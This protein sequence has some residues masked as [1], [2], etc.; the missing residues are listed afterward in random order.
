[1]NTSISLD[2]FRR[3]NLQSVLADV[4]G[5]ECWQYHMVI[6]KLG[7]ELEER[8]D[9]EAG[10]AARLLSTVCSFFFR[11][12]KGLN[13]WQPFYI[14]GGERSPMADDLE[15]AELKSLGDFI[16]EIEDPELKARVADVLWECKQGY[17]FGRIAVEAYQRA[18]EI[19]ENGREW[20]HFVEKLQRAASLAAKLERGKQVHL[21]VIARIEEKVAK[22][23]GD[24]GSGML[25]HELL[26]VVMAHGFGN[27]EAYAALCER[28]GS[29]FRSAKQWSFS[30]SYWSLAAAWHRRAKNEDDARRCR[31]QE[32]ETMVA[33]AQDADDRMRIG[34][35]YSAGW[36]MRGIEILRETG[37]DAERIAV[38]HAEM[39]GLQREALNDL[40]TF[41]VD[42]RNIPG[43]AETAKAAA[44]DV[45]KHL[46][47]LRLDEA[48]ARLANITS[49]TDVGE[50]RKTMANA[51]GD[52]LHQ[53]V[54][55]GT[56]D[57]EGKITDQ[58]EGAAVTEDPSE[59]H[60]QKRMFEW[61]KMSLWPLACDWYIEPA[62][63]TIRLEHRLR[64]Q[65]L[66]FLVSPNP[67]VPIGHEEIYLRGVIAGFNDDHLVATHLLVPQ[68]EHSIRMILKRSGFLT[69]TLKS[70][71]QKEMDLGGLL[72][73]EKTIEIFGED[74]IFDLRGILIEKF[75]ENLRNNMAH[76]FLPSSSFN[77]AGSCYL[78]W[79][80]VRLLWL[81]YAG[82]QRP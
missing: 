76:G 47:G 20:I 30:V 36:L 35:S 9:A 48:I 14:G 32:G 8:G 29:D 38:L 42:P 72:T 60:L 16:D 12:S 24:L 45:H 69:S 33:Q 55:M 13:P 43:Y 57:F 46:S 7:K 27:P 6:G 10:R 66:A 5:M 67:F 11:P 53:R 44:A 39:I 19:T 56:L 3:L 54:G 26:D 15:E 79:L 49:P 62:R 73:H 31:N 81:G 2:A 82:V 59:L 77:E 75:G 70:G 22:F 68:L 63:R 80:V 1:M 41:T 71:L 40:N 50:L 61:G 64:F 4:Q 21:E 78:W 23:S 37:T 25:V 34:A 58:V 65:D 18:A 74:V 52:F 28:L 17:R 51:A